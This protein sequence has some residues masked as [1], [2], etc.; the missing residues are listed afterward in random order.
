MTRRILLAFVGLTVAI[1]VAAVIPLGMEA[2]AHEYHDYVEDSI[3]RARTAAG[4]AEERLGD[5]H[6]GPI[7]SDLVAT[8]R[9]AGDR[10]VI[11]DTG[12]KVLAG[13]RPTA[14]IPASL[15]AQAKA[16]A[17]PSRRI[18]DQLIV[19]V[20]VQEAGP[21]LGE[22]ALVI[23]TQTLE[24]RMMMFWLT[25]AAVATAALLAAAAAGLGLARWVARPL[26]LLD[27]TARQLGDG[28][29]T[30]R[31]PAGSGPGE[32]RRL[33]ATFNTM[34]GRLET[35]VHGHR[36]VIADVSHQLRTPLAALRLRLDLLAA[37]A[38]ERT[39]AELS[40][41]LGELAR[42]SRLVDGLL[43]VARAENVVPHPVP[44]DVRDVIMERVDAWV[45]V[46]AERGVR[47]DTV[48]PRRVTALL[49]EGYLEQILDNLL[50]NALDAIGEGHRVTVSAMPVMEG[51]RVMVADNGPGMSQA[52]RDRAFRRFASGSPG[53]TGLGLAIVHRLI[54]SSG[55]TARLAETA[56]GGLT[57][58]LD[59]PAAPPVNALPA[60]HPGTASS[61]G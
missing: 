8:S 26:A 28:D 24:Q 21:V 7:L 36:A 29:L 19:V 14:A 35:L 13:G 37:D 6:N 43:A 42:L 59:L 3:N 30:V 60:G 61:A 41:A 9:R 46:A 39:A 34:A 17:T 55:G 33:A 15:I 2:T 31:A 12:G 23:P 11:F 50:A 5:H 22:V 25:L 38:D 45:P 1:L 58:I 20:P 52:E 48:V 4:E 40:G 51:V 16:G 53:G 47:I 10:L 54:S 27:T 44:V 18:D 57:V 32:L 49:G 56:G